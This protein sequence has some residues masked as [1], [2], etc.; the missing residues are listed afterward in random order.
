MYSTM[1]GVLWRRMNECRSIIL[2]YMKFCFSKLRKI[3]WIL[4]ILYALQMW[5][6]SYIPMLIWKLWLIT[7]VCSHF[8]SQQIPL[9]LNRISNYNNH[10]VTWQCVHSLGNRSYIG[11]G[12][13]ANGLHC[14]F[15][16]PRTWG[17]C[18]CK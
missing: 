11:G 18:C 8:Y 15:Q 7:F 6:I 14:T 10:I 13:K 2:N 3:S 4:A 5:K 17:N 1:T 16:Q 12:Y 9:P